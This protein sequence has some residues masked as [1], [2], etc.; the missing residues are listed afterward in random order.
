MTG[1]SILFGC[2]CEWIPLL[3]ID[4][5][6][7]L[8]ISFLNDTTKRPYLHLFPCI[9]V[10]TEVY[11]LHRRE[12][13]WLLFSWFQITLLSIMLSKFIRFLHFYFRAESI[14]FCIRTTYLFLTHVLM[15]LSWKV[16]WFMDYGWSRS[17]SPSSYLFLSIPLI[18]QL[19]A[20]LM[21]I[22]LMEIIMLSCSKSYQNFMP[23][24][25]NTIILS[26]SHSSGC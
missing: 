17:H 21:G 13:V 20:F 15:A 14:P 7:P 26:L 19:P 1:L 9:H 8:C 4:W 16:Q 2:P 10:C 25:D 5:H 12:N 6:H 18:F 23:I 24:G 3:L 11:I 22:L